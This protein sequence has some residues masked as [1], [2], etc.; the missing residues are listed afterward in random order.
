MPAHM[1]LKVE[2][3][4]T[5]VGERGM[6]GDPLVVGTLL[7]GGVAQT[8]LTHIGCEEAV[9]VIL[10]Q[11]L[12]IEVHGG[13]H[14]SVKQGDLIEVEVFGVKDALCT[15]CCDSACHHSEDKAFQLHGLRWV[16]GS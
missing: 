1:S 5:P 6:L 11:C 16:I 8:S 7:V 10:E 13:L 14:R 15:G 3:V 9:C 2:T 4:V 12:E